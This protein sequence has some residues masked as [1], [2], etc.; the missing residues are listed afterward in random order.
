ML[1]A[2]F[3][4]WLVAP[5]I[6]LGPFDALVNFLLAGWLMGPYL[7]CVILL[8]HI[9]TLHL[10]SD[11]GMSHFRRTLL[12]TRNFETGS[13]CDYLSGG[14]NHH[15][16]HHLFPTVPISR[17][18]EAR[19]ITRRFC[20]QHGLP[21]NETTWRAGQKETISY[22]GRLSRYAKSLPTNSG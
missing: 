19:L 15:V 7:G 4:L 9:G 12:T 6:V 2:H 5:T 10:P 3:A 22:L 21:Y 11:H 13:L 1:I 16:E 14:T 8:N 17:L 18:G 20:Q